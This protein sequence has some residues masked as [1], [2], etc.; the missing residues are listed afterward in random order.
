MS[1]P[2]PAN[3]N[4]PAGAVAPAQAK[5]L[6]GGTVTVKVEGPG[7]VTGVTSDNPAVPLKA[8]TGRSVGR[9]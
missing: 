3:N 1:G 5:A 7:Q 4:R 6:V 2:V 9:P 8:N